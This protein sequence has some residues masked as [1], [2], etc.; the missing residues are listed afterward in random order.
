MC[1][2]NWKCGCLD[3]EESGGINFNNIVIEEKKVHTCS[4]CGKL[5][6]SSGKE[7]GHGTN[8]CYCAWDKLSRHSLEENNP[9]EQDKEVIVVE[10][11]FKLHLVG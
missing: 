2:F 1:L 3:S 10:K 6:G 8:R 9:T 4:D 5:C 11:K 7:Y